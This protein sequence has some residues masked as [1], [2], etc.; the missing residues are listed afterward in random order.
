MDV[1]GGGDWVRVSES[2]S[3]QA[4]RVARRSLLAV[5]WTYGGGQRHKTT[6]ECYSNPPR[7]NQGDGIGRGT[8]NTLKHDRAKHPLYRL[9]TH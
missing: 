6:S 9:S 8:L 1:G 7:T 3:V 4:E 2:L 5:A